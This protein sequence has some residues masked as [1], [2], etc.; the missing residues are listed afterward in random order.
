MNFYI[1]I[2]GKDDK[3]MMSVFK[4]IKIVSGSIYIYSWEHGIL[5]LQFLLRIP[6]SYLNTCIP[7]I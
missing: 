7:N 2:F 4:I 6:K 3:Y 1:R 5:P